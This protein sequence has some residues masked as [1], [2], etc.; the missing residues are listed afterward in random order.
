MPAAMLFIRQEVIRLHSC[1]VPDA[2]LQIYT[3]KIRNVQI[4]HVDVVHPLGYFTPK[5]QKQ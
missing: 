1:E 2:H 5:Y 3:S 4:A